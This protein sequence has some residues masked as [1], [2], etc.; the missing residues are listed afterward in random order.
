M[1]GEF[2]SLESIRELLER[3]RDNRVIRSPESNLVELCQS[4]S[5]GLAGSELGVRG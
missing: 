1:Q 2:P 4:E 5:L 3:V